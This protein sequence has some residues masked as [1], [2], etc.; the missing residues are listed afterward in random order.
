MSIKKPKK[1]LSNNQK[2]ELDAALKFLGCSS[3]VR[4]SILSSLESVRIYANFLK[5]QDC[6]YKYSG[7]YQTLKFSSCTAILGSTLATLPK[8]EPEPASVLLNV[9]EVKQIEPVEP[10][11]VLLNEPEI[12]QIE[13]QVQAEPDKPVTLSLTIEQPEPVK[14]GRGKAKK[15]SP[16][17]SSLTCLIDDVDIEALNQLAITKDLSVSYFVR[18]AIKDFLKYQ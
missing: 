14:K 6:V 18:A 13:E 3:F 7:E 12:K 8:T 10:D 17:R 15:E 11:P 2:Y 9:S 16:V 5:L 4:S 1:V